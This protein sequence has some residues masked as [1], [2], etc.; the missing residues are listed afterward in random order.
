MSARSRQRC[1]IA[2]AII[3]LVGIAGVVLV[4]SKRRRVDLSLRAGQRTRA[5][6]PIED[7]WG[8]E[9]FPASDPPQSW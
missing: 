8:R 4:R 2:G 9:S 3:A 5:G 6:E 1:L 7:E